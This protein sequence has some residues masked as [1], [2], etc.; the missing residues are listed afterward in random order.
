VLLKYYALG[1]IQGHWKWHHSMDRIWVPIRLP[2]VTTMHDHVL[3]CLRDKWRYGSKIAILRPLLHNSCDYFRDIFFSNEPGYKLQ[4][5]AKCR[6]KLQLSEQ[7]APTL[8]TTDYR[9]NCE[10]NSRMYLTKQ[11]HCNKLANRDDFYWL[12]LWRIPSLWSSPRSVTTRKAT[13]PKGLRLMPLPDLQ[14]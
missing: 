13:E 1:V 2:I 10:V 4:C 8:Q 7:D 14:I 5:S 3:Y 11:G 6:R 9:R 12:M